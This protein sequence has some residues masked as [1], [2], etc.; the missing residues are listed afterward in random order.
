MHLG[1]SPYNVRSYDNLSCNVI[2]FLN[3]YHAKKQTFH[4]QIIDKLDLVD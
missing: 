4:K 2:S 3:E 1:E